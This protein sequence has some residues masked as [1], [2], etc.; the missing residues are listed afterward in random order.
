MPRN[1]LDR[2]SC[3]SPSPTSAAPGRK[4]TQH[5]PRH[6]PAR[7]PQLSRPQGPRPPPSTPGPALAMPKPAPF[8][9]A[10]PAGRWPDRPPEGAGYAYDV[11]DV[12]EGAS[13]VGPPVEQKLAGDGALGG[14]IRDAHGSATHRP[15]T[16]LEATPSTSDPGSAP[17]RPQPS[18]PCPGHRQ[19]HVSL[20]QGQAHG[21]RIP[22]TAV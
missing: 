17:G 16:G 13:C 3:R 20:S 7:A 15:R 2:T 22:G 10:A 18:G 5:G 11:Y 6:R 12:V 19:P 8:V 1:S 21:A 14:R 4:S 9:V